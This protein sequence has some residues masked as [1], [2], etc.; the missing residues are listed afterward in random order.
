[1]LLVTV[2]LIS[3]VDGHREILG[4]GKISLQEWNDSGTI[5]SYAV[6]LS[7]R[8]GKGVWKRGVVTGFPRKRLLAWDLL[9]RALKEVVGD[10][11]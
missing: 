7:R 2:E 8:S 11:K 10:R 9:Y 6:D 4:Q 5:G 3:A 1:M